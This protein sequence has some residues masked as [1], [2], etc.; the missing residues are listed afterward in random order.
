MTRTPRTARRRGFTLVELL[1]SAALTVLIMAVVAVAFQAALKAHSDLHSVSSLADQLRAVDVILSRDLEADHLWDDDTGR[2]VRVSKVP[3]HISKSYPS[4][5]AP[6]QH[7]YFFLR[8]G[9]APKDRFAPP[10]SAY[11][12]TPP[13][14]PPLEYVYEGTEDNRPS[15]RAND[16]MIA[17]TVRLDD[18]TDDGKP[19]RAETMFAAK[20]PAGLPQG[21]SNDLVNHP[22][23]LLRSNPSGQ[24]VSRWAEVAYFLTP[25]GL[26]VTTDGMPTGATPVQLFTLRRHQWLLTPETIR[27][28]NNPSNNAP[29]S[30][31]TAPYYQMN[32]TQYPELSAT[33]VLPPPGPYQV[34]TT[35]TPTTVKQPN[36]RFGGAGSAPTPSVDGSDVL[37][38]NVVSF[39]VRVTSD[40]GTVMNPVYFHPTASPSAATQVGPGEFHDLGLWVRDQR[41]VSPPNAA[42]PVT[43]NVVGPGVVDFATFDTTT[44]LGVIPL[45][46]PPNNMTTHPPALPNGQTQVIRQL[47]SVEITVRVYDFKTF[48][49]RQLTLK[50]DL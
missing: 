4:W 1:V 13:T 28:I 26:K 23:N 38:S 48:R 27:L 32:P 30:L 41:Y 36:R 7:G 33:P 19:A 50:K 2:A 10:A 3:K 17:M 20:A 47:R 43:F 25:N 37:L 42:Q 14:N 5:S 22:T 46:P 15:F 44:N 9:S 31:P 35:N 11:R 6:H 45:A 34:W 8:Q 40:A 49:T 39:Q 16:H 12:S 18:A 29:D 21:S 24:Y